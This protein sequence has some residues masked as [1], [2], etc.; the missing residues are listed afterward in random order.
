M[1]R[2]LVLWFVL[3]IAGFLTG[4]ILQYA[5]VQRL[6]QELSASTKQLGSCQ[7]G[8]QLSQLRDI[9]TMMYLEVAQKNYGKAG[10]YSKEFFDQAQRIVSSTED[11][12]L[13]NLLRDTLTTRD[14][15]TAD[16]AK[17]D[18]AALS[19]IQLVLSKLEQTA[20]H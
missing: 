13:R 6:Q 18:A 5:R 4:F 10:E 19:E 16:L 3:L 12:A 1:P 7:S 14:Q 20:K 2:K 8:E 9:A 17:G 15:I 11:P